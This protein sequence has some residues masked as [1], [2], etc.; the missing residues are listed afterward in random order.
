MLRADFRVLAGYRPSATSVLPCPIHVFGGER[1]RVSRRELEAWRQHTS[2]AFSVALL[3]GD[4]FYLREQ[5]A[6]LTGLI[7]AA[8]EPAPSEPVP[9]AHARGELLS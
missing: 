4:H 2:D 9:F 1:D 7:A 8:L 5:E 6:C 3:P